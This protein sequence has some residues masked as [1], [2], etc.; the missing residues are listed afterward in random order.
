MIEEENKPRI[1]IA[2]ESARKILREAGMKSA[3]IVLNEIIKHIRKTIKLEIHPR[4]LGSVD[5][6]HFLKSNKAIIGYNNTKPL[7]RQ[8]FT[9][10]HELGHVL[11]GHADSESKLDFYNDDPKETEANQ[12]AAELLMPIDLF[13]VD[14]KKL[15][16]DVES[17]AKLYQVSKEAAWWHVYNH[18]IFCK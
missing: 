15:N 14:L 4:D 8:R 18:K 7:L 11:L 6:L 13:K 17:V 10:A 3:P 12:F 5:G 1:K 16:D 2:R 9:V